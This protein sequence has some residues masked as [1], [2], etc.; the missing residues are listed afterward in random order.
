[1][2]FGCRLY[3]GLAGVYRLGFVV[4][5]KNT[6]VLVL[7][8]FARMTGAFLIAHAF[9][10]TQRKTYTI[11]RLK[12]VSGFRRETVSS[13]IRESS[14][15]AMREAAPP[16]TATES[17]AAKAPQSKAMRGRPSPPVPSPRSRARGHKAK[18]CFYFDK[19]AE[20]RTRI[21]NV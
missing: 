17:P 15:S 9:H 12:A 20:F 3:Q 1:M 2:L 14:T 19:L 11:C 8:V 16:R 4:P 10:T 21:D 18:A 7:E 6:P 13:K 5:A